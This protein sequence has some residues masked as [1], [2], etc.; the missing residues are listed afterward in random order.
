MYYNKDLGHY[1]DYAS[2]TFEKN[3][4]NNNLKSSFQ[5]KNTNDLTETKALNIIVNNL[6]EM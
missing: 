3:Q 1:V 6:L 4:L 5:S 2:V